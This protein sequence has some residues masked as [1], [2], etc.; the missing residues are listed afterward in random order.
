MQEAGGKR[1]L[2]RMLWVGLPLAIGSA[3]AWYYRDWIAARFFLR[4]LES[5]ERLRRLRVDDVV[6][7]LSIEPGS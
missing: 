3:L 2:K 1:A 7:L 6:R 4:H 5:D